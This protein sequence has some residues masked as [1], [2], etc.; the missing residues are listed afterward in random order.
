MSNATDRFDKVRLRSDGWIEYDFSNSPLIYNGLWLRAL[1]S[2]SL[3]YAF[4]L[5]LLY[6]VS[7]SLLTAGFTVFRK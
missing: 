6:S 3:G 4:V 2:L 1:L 7:N 5:V